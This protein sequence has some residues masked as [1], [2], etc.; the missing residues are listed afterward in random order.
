MAF[1]PGPGQPGEHKTASLAAASAVGLS[2]GAAK[3]V[4]GVSLALAPGIW[5]IFGVINFQFAANTSYT[6][7]Q[8]GIGTVADTLSANENETFGL[9]MPATVP[10]G[11]LD[12]TFAV[13]SIYALV[14]S[15]AATTYQLVA[16]A[17]F[18]VN[19]CKAYGAIRAR[20]IR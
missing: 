3:T 7:L 18:T 15:D 14:R 19:T 9:C 2:T 16:K 6:I 11:S 17:T 1:L 20:R 12:L 13:P 10:T 8:G 4:T 5:E